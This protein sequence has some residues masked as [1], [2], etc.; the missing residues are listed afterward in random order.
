MKL[1]SRRYQAES[2]EDEDNA[3]AV[4]SPFKD[5]GIMVKPLCSFE[6]V[7]TDSE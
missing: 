6:A 3:P 1:P 7:Q 4:E 2:D 5:K